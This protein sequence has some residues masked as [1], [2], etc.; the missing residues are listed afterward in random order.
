MIPDSSSFVY[1][2]S[3]LEPYHLPIYDDPCYV[4]HNIDI[5]LF[6]RYRLSLHCCIITHSQPLYPSYDS[7]PSQVGRSIYKF[8]RLSSLIFR[9]PHGVDSYIF[10]FL[11]TSQ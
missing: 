2:R 9:F 7:I 10:I 1:I 3:F 11:Y 8:T 4:A 5:M 6:I